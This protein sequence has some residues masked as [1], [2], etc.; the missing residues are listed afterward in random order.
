MIE[1]GQI[2]PTF[3]ILTLPDVGRREAGVS[4]AI[5]KISQYFFKFL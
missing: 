2:G 5:V 4:H 3:S 1:F